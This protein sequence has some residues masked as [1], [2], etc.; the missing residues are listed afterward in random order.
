MWPARVGRARLAALAACQRLA[1]WVAA[2]EAEVL[3]ALQDEAQVDAADPDD[4]E[5]LSEEVGAVLRLRG[6]YAKSRMLHAAELVRRLPDALALLGAGVVTPVQARC[7]PKPSSAWTTRRARR[8]RPGCWCGPVTS[9]A[10]SSG[11]H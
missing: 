4:R 11:N 1:G 6:D 10:P 2:R 7:W 9:R 8:C 3:G 5:W